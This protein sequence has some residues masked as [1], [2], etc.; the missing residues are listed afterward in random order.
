MF[1]FD[2]IKKFVLTLAVFALLASAFSGATCLMSDHSD[3]GMSGC[4][5]VTS[6]AEA[7]CLLP[8]A[9]DDCALNHLTFIRSF[10][11]FI[12]QTAFS[13]VL[14]AIG[15]S[16][17]TAFAMSRYRIDVKFT[18]LIAKAYLERFRS[19]FG[20]IFNPQFAWLELL[21]KRDY[22]SHV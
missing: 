2:K 17:A 22:Y 16:L 20:I 1:S 7:L 3:M 11:N 5:K 15:L 8:S 18:N 4:A 9:G 14:V 21:Q 10:L 13:A 6:M 19:N 12:N